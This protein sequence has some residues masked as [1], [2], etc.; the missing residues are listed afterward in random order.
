MRGPGYLADVDPAVHGRE[1]QVAGSHAAQ[2]PVEFFKPL[3]AVG[4]RLVLVCGLHGLAQLF[5]VSVRIEVRESWEA[6][7]ETNPS[8]SQSGT[9]L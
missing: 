9:R 6:L 2:E 4:V 1:H 3:P 7:S 5:I 8:R